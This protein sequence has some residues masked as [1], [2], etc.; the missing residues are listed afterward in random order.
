[1]QKTLDKALNPRYRARRLDLELVL[2]EA[3]DVGSATA[4]SFRSRDRVVIPLSRFSFFPAPAAGPV[5][6]RGR[7]GP[8]ALP[9]VRPAND[10]KEV[11]K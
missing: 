7:F 8:G 6:G 2:Y 11:W 5:G 4:S 3:K 9:L 1:M 10:E